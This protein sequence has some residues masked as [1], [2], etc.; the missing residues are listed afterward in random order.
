MGRRLF[1][2]PYATIWQEGEDINTFFDFILKK[3]GKN[4][5]REHY[6]DMR[7]ICTQNLDVCKKFA[8]GTNYSGLYDAKNM[9][10][11]LLTNKGR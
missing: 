7:K 11:D 1:C 2:P 4:K 9:L 3:F 6:T 8:Y 5:K 10:I